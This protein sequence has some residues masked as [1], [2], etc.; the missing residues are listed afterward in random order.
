MNFHPLR[1]WCKSSS[2]AA[3]ENFHPQCMGRKGCS[4]VGQRL[5]EGLHS[6]RVCVNCTPLYDA[7]KC[8][9]IWFTMCRSIGCTAFV[10]WQQSEILVLFQVPEVLLPMTS[11]CE[12]HRLCARVCVC[13]CVCV[14]VFAQ[15]C[16]V[17]VC[18]FAQVCMY[19]F[20]TFIRG[21]DC[22]INFTKS[23]SMCRHLRWNV[24]VYVL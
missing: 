23:A 12:I 10:L 17:C 19:V 3:W 18:V 11:S 1:T 14:C 8:L 9:L 22:A 4:V 21:W 7:E 13:V 20:I 6:T 16:G 5:K 24:C 2:L 15:V